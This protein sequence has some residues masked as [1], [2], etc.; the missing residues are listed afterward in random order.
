MITGSSAGLGYQVA[1]SCLSE[2]QTVVVTSRTVERATQAA[3]QLRKNLPD[4]KHASVV[5]MQLDLANFD[6]IE[7]FA[8][9]ICE[10][11][12][13]WTTLVNNAGAKVEKPLK[14]TNQ[15]FEWHYGVNHLGHFLLTGLLLPS[16]EPGANITSVSSITAR[17]GQSGLWQK[18]YAELM[19]FSVGELYASSK[20]ANLVFALEL[21]RRLD[22]A[23]LPMTSNAA[24]PGFA[25]AEPYGPSGLRLVEYLLA[26]SSRAGSTP[27]TLAS[28]PKG[29]KSRAGEYYGPSVLELWGRPRQLQLPKSVQPH[30]GSE[31]WKL[32]EQQTGFSYL[33]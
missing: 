21:N 18:T 10:R 8:E 29:S 4:S 9:S 20:L 24:H 30:L 28:D 5:P 3:N 25:R 2:G 19:Q 6:S 27:I 23:K 31:L 32:S 17:K 16:A 7:R 13:S 26:Q 12:G 33:S 14:Q 11:V 1:R 22:A 15:G